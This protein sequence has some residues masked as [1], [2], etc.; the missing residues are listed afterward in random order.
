MLRPERCL[1]HTCAS[2]MRVCAFEGYN[3][4]WHGFLGTL[5]PGMHASL[6]WHCMQAPV[7]EWA[8]MH[9]HWLRVHGLGLT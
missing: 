2:L 3:M 4:R 1:C 9:W 6:C 5:L 8:G 7:S